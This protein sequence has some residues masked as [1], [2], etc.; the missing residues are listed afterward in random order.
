MRTKN[1]EN[2]LILRENTFKEEIKVRTKESIKE[3]LTRC[4]EKKLLDLDNFCAK[5]CLRTGN[6]ETVHDFYIDMILI[7]MTAYHLSLE[8]LDRLYG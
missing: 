3:E 4:H 7:L 6:N 2:E 5:E 1:G 8:E